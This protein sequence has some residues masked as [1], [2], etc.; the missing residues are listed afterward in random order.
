MAAY[1]EEPTPAPI[2]RSPAAAKA[3]AGVVSPSPV[4]GLPR[5]ADLD[6][7]L[8][9]D[10]SISAAPRSSILKSGRGSR[11]SAAADDDAPKASTPV[12]RLSFAADVSWR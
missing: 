12:K 9:I 8:D 5:L 6:G 11:F 1:E 4:Q 3:P 10:L 2:L 7:D